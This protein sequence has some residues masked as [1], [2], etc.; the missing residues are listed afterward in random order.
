MRASIAACNGRFVEMEHDDYSKACG[1][2]LRIAYRGVAMVLFITT[3][4][5]GR[6]RRKVCSG[7]RL[8]LHEQGELAA[9]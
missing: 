4:M 8:D 3:D 6:A 7:P 9:A 1:R 5:R 2:S